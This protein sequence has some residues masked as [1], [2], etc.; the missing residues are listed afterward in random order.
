[1]NSVPA[2]V[3]VTAVLASPSSVSQSPPDFSGTWTIDRERSESPHQGD[4]F[5]PPTYVI[6][7]TGSD[8]TIETLRGSA[9]STARYAIGPATA[10]QQPLP[11]Q[12]EA[13]PAGRAY[14]MGAALVTEG[15]STIQGQTV[16]VRETRSLDATGTTM[17]LQTLLVVQHGYTLKGAQ[18]YGAATDVYRRVAPQRH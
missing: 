16:S 18:N 11:A 12:G 7:Q 4:A 8:V 15:Q 5:T 9:R 10:P 13:R 2:V 6:T 17:T 14:W 1:M 3:L